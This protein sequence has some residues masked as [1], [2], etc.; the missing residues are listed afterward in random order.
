MWQKIYK[1][2]RKQFKNILASLSNIY[3][4]YSSNIYFFDMLHMKRKALIDFLMLNTP[5]QLQLWQTEHA[6]IL[7]TWLPF[8]SSGRREYCRPHFQLVSPLKERKRCVSVVHTLSVADI[9]KFST[10]VFSWSEIIYIRCVSQ[11]AVRVSGFLPMKFTPTVLTVQSQN[12]LCLM[13]LLDIAYS[14]NLSFFF[15]FFITY[16]H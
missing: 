10:E 8:P 11:A 13:T 2:K 4:I 15:F 6:C 7:L 12:M 14:K 3:L 1:L 5:C 9:S 16:Q